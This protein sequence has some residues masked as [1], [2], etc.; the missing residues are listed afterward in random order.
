MVEISNKS[1]T[2]GLTSVMSETLAKATRK[3]RPTTG[4]DTTS[5]SASIIRMFDFQLPRD[6]ILLDHDHRGDYIYFRHILLENWRLDC[7]SQV[8]A[9]R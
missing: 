5:Y 9:N 3:F 1:D 2:K 6:Y 8:S 4:I 7:V